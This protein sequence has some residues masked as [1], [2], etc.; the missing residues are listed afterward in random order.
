M[1]G[2]LAGILFGLMPLVSFA[3]DNQAALL[4]CRFP[5]PPVIPDGATAEFENM[6]AAGLSVRNWVK[7]MQG[8]LDCLD[9]LTTSADIAGEDRAKAV[10]LYNN[11][12][13]Q[14]NT[15][16]AAFNHQ[17]EVFRDPDHEERNNRRLRKE[18][19]DSLSAEQASFL[20]YMDQH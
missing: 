1:P 8:S 20:D 17:L 19:S 14:I 2:K 7:A 6:D 13:D 5:E 12:V 4:A 10:A 15:V 18:D 16:A 11:G 9:A 3:S